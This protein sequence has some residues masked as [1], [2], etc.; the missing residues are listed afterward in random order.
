VRRLSPVILV[1]LTVSLSF[2]IARFAY[3]DAAQARIHFERGRT[4]FEVDEYRK[5]IEEFKAAHIE[6]PDPAFLYNIAECYRH[7]GETR[8]ALIYYRRFLSAAPANDRSR[9]TV[10]KRIAELQASAPPA[11]GAPSPETAGSAAATAGG[12]ATTAPESGAGAQLSAAPPPEQPAT[13][14]VGTATPTGESDR[15][16][17][18]PFYARGWFLASVAVVLVAGAVGIWAASRNPTSVPGTPLGNQDTHWQ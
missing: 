16:E 9:P 4:Y 13:T 1:S 18:K 10:E 15:G 7:L 17:R 12:A 3:A 8:D 14:L 2:G 6:K 5:A 11:P